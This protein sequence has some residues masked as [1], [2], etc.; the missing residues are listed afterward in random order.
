MTD[1][2]LRGI[3][4][5]VAGD[6]PTALAQLTASLR[7]DGAL[8]TVHGS[9][10][11]LA[12]LMALLVVNVLVV[13]LAARS[14]DHALMLIRE[15]R[16]RTPNDGGRVPIIALFA[17]S[18]HDEQQLVA[19]DVDSVVRKPADAAELSR[20]IRDVFAASPARVREAPKRL[21]AR[22]RV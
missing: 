8:V 5:A 3:H 19:A 20:I 9:A 7:D 13:D 2:R 10:Q 21:D 11:S 15:V 16:A 4:V 22:G 14:R 6:D 1:A 18:D 17:G 12:R